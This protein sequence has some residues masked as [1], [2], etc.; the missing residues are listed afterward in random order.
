M[1]APKLDFNLGGGVAWAV[2]VQMSTKMIDSNT[3][4]EVNNRRRT[5][6]IAFLLICEKRRR[7]KCLNKP[8][9]LLSDT[10][11]HPR[12]KIYTALIV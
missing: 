11:I 7:Q 8:L 1:R 12:D 9:G 2:T 6:I 3:I 10:F 5:A 4:A